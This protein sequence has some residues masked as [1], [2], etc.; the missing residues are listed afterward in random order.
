M[1]RRKELKLRAAPDL[2][3]GMEIIHQFAIDL[4]GKG[5]AAAQIFQT[6]ISEE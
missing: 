6:T 2:F 4:L 1:I 5:T 3:I